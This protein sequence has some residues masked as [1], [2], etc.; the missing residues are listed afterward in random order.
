MQSKKIIISHYKYRKPS[1]RNKQRRQSGTHT[2]NSVAESTTPSFIY[3]TQA[4]N[5]YRHRSKR[6]KASQRGG[7]LALPCP[8][9]PPRPRVPEV[10]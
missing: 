4:V 3:Q 9:L 2:Q 1:E 10:P 7:L 8:A 5:P 6:T